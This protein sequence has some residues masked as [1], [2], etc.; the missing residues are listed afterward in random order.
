MLGWAPYA[1]YAS[2]FLY[3]PCDCWAVFLRH[4]ANTVCECLGYQSPVEQTKELHEVQMDSRI[5]QVKV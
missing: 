2:T 5:H 4:S 3:F 1:Q